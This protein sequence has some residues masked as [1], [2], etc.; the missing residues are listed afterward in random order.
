MN[1]DSIDGHT[2]F[3]RYR[4]YISCTKIFFLTSAGNDRQDRVEMPYHD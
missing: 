2:P 1:R 3:L 4:G